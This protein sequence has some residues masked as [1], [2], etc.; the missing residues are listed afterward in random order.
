MTTTRTERN[1]V[2]KEAVVRHLISG[3]LRRTELDV[4]R[5][6]WSPSTLYSQVNR[7]CHYLVKE[8]LI[9]RR[10]LGFGA[11]PYR[12]WLVPG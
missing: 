1:V 7:V 3:C 12:Y 9:T 8:D 11:S 10:G 2:P 4:A 6:T 5:A